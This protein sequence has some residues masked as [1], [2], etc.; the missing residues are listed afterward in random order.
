MVI[1]YIKKDSIFQTGIPSEN[2]HVSSEHTNL[3]PCVYFVT[4]VAAITIPSDT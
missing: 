2:G 3:A 1:N 4:A